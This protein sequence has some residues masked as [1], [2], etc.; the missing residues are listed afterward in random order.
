MGKY[1]WVQSFYC[2]VGVLFFVRDLT[3][4]VPMDKAM[5]HAFIWP[6]AQWET[7]KTAVVNEVD[8][9]KPQVQQLLDRLYR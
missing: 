1:L 4:N 2:I 9:V 3:G 8:Q 6:Y 5:L 7:M